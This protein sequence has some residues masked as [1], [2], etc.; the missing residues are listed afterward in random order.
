MNL[1]IPY[2]CVPDLLLRLVRTLG[3]SEEGRALS[4]ALF[5]V[6]SIFSWPVALILR[7]TRSPL[8]RLLTSST[9]GILTMVGV[10][11]P[12]TALLFVLF[13]F[14]FYFLVRMQFMG[15]WLTTV[16]VIALLSAVHY[17][18][19]LTN[20]SMDRMSYT[21]TLMMIAAK[22]SMFGFHI[23]DG[24]KL[25]S[26]TRL[27]IHPHINEQRT[28]TA[29][30]PDQVS[31]FKFM[32]Y[33]FE[34]MGGVVGPLFTYSEYMDYVHNRRDFEGLP[35]ASLVTP[36]FKSVLRAFAT[37]GTYIYISKIEWLRGE[38][39]VS[40]WYLGLPFFHKV[41][42]S[43][44][45]VV[46]CR[47]AFYAVWTLSEVS[48]TISGLA[49]QPP[50]RF[51]RGRNVNI[52][53]FELGTH[54]SQKTNNWN[55]RIADLWLKAC[56]YQRVEAVPGPL[57]P[58]ISSR[59]ALA[60]LIT[61]MTSAF[62]HGW[63]TGYMI[64]FLSLGLCNWSEDALRRKVYPLLPTGLVHSRIFT[65][66][67]WLHTWSSIN[68][69]FTPFFLLTWE[70]TNTYFNSIFWFMHLYHFAI[71]VVTSLMKTPTAIKHEKQS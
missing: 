37:V 46:P 3:F 28:A 2:P 35:S 11:G 12:E 16:T 56:I 54:F 33:M 42:I 39:L 60:N 41:L 20:T 17:D 52:R 68:F 48:C 71:L 24:V 61:K 59:K 66:V 22:I 65:I 44:I 63:Y 6:L 55:I 32:C 29:I 8:I 34:F 14:P 43:L 40:S 31:F 19:I 47:L 4:P 38:T 1:P 21:G 30:L 67:A 7:F 58:F 36:S 50:H 13:V 25:S 53:E 26:G 23:D 5:V 69:F 10:Y 15:P 57:K 27:S 9:V 49:F 18:S 45:I 70:K 64:S 62:W 51:T